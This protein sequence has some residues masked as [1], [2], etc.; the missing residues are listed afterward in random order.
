MIRLSKN[1][2]TSE[3]H[4]AEIEKE[5]EE[6]HTDPENLKKLDELRFQISGLI[7]KNNLNYLREYTDRLVAQFNKDCDWFYPQR[8]E[9]RP[10]P[11][12]TALI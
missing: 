5:Y 3:Q 12:L 1:M 9:R 8:A 2:A 10:T 11:F 6:K 4:L 7:G